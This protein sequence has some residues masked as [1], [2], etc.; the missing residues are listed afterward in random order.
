MNI[1]INAQ[2]LTLSPKQEEAFRLK[3]EHLARL[4]SRLEDESS[5]LRM[6]LIFR[7]TR[8]P[9]DAYECHLTCFVPQ[10]ILRAEAQGASLENAVD[11]IVDKM[12]TQIE[13]YKDKLHHLHERG[14]KTK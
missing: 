2:H 6:D 7:E 10:D 12:K 5:E 1:K 14:K 3:I 11:E 13:R 9:A 4:A 8:R